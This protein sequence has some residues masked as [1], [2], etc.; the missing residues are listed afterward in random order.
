MEAAPEAFAHLPNTIL[1]RFQFLDTPD[2][3]YALKVVP[4]DRC[5]EMHVAFKPRPWGMSRAKRVIHASRWFRRYLFNLGV[6]HL[7]GITS[8]DDVR[9]ERFW[10]FLGFDNIQK[11]LV[12]TGTVTLPKGEANEDIGG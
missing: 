7:V 12:A 4:S 5:A 11:L 9:T 1:S 3:Y 2:A 6:T 10:R 8:F